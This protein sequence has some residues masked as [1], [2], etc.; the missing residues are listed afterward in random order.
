MTPEIEKEL[1]RRKS[2]NQCFWCQHP[3]IKTIVPPSRL[4][5][6]Q[7][8]FAKT[9]DHLVPV[10]K[11]GRLTVSCCAECNSLK[12]GMDPIKFAEKHRPHM[13]GWFLDCVVGE[14]NRIARVNPAMTKNQKKQKRLEEALKKKEYY[15][16]VYTL[17]YSSKR[18]A[19]DLPRPIP[20]TKIKNMRDKTIKNM[21]AVP[22]GYLS[23]N[24]EITYPLVPW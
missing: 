5:P 7:R 12:G 17:G 22:L 21:V 15:E 4:T 11:G 24:L 10:L 18:V 3:L 23:T 1:H 20:K 13:L 14:A 9:R 16:G 8:K 2:S 6:E 19:I